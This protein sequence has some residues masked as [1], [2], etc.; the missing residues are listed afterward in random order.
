MYSMLLC[1]PVVNSFRWLAIFNM[2]VGLD[3][4]PEFLSIFHRIPQFVDHEKWYSFITAFFNY[5]WFGLLA[6]DNNDD[7]WEL[8]FMFRT[9]DILWKQKTTFFL[10]GRGIWIYRKIM[11]IWPYNIVLQSQSRMMNCD[12]F[13]FTLLFTYYL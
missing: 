10:Y 1:L 3:L 13:L 6:N 7:N 9:T 2:S 8:I 5:A 4:C 11:L 12:A